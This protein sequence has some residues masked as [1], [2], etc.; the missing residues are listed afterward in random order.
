MTTSGGRKAASGRERVAPATAEEAIRRA[1]E[2]GRQAI[3]EAAAALRCLLDAASLATTGVPSE[4]QA[5][6]RRAADWLARAESL[7]RESGGARWMEDVAAALDAEIARWEASSR[8]DPEARAVL[9]A[10]LGVREIL[11]EVGLRPRAERSRRSAR[12]PAAAEPSPR[13]PSEPSERLHPIGA[14]RLERVTVQRG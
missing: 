8:D 5:G 11:W 2:H 12:P 10:F 1:R 4:A 7:A 9:R 13:A 3:A 6:L 14:R